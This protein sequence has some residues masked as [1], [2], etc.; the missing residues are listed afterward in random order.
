[1]RKVFR[2]ELISQQGGMVDRHINVITDDV[3]RV[4]PLLKNNPK[5][6]DQTIHSITSCGE[7]LIDADCIR[8]PGTLF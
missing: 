1:M 5:Y 7:C 6:I 4:A 2:V 3:R 8:E